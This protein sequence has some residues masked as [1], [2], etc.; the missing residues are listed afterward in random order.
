MMSGPITVL[1]LMDWITSFHTVLPL[2]GRHVSA[3][4]FTQDHQYCLNQ[5]KNRN[6]LIVK[7]F[8]KNKPSPDVIDMILLEKLADKYENIIWFDDSDGVGITHF[9]VLPYVTKYYKKQLFKNPNLY[10]KSWYGRELFTDYYNDKHQV[11]DEV[12]YRRVP[13]SCEKDIEKLELGWNLGVGIYPRQVNIQRIA[14]RFGR[15]FGPRALSFMKNGGNRTRMHG[16]YTNKKP[17]VHARYSVVS[18]PTV[19][20]QRNL[21]SKLISD[22]P[23][24]LKGSVPSKQFNKEMMEVKA[25]LC[26]FGWGEITFRDFEAIM[27]GAI[28][29][30]PDMDHLDTFPAVYFKGETYISLDWDFNGFNEIISEVLADSDAWKVARNATAVYHSELRKVDE[31]VQKLLGDFNL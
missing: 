29:I 1:I 16:S 2:L 26:P 8:E 14:L 13:L 3:F 23:S 27:Y 31:K 22:N 15:W 5:D 6:L 4:K 28:M 12:E 18:R 11:C 10:L 19:A 17:L 7:Y 21:L 30:K 9:E 24:I 25:V 20:F